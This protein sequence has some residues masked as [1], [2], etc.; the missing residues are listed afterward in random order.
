VKH[1]TSCT[2]FKKYLKNSLVGFADIVIREL[3]LKIH[4][5]TLHE[6]GSARWASPPGR[7]WIKDGQLV[8]DDDGKIQY[9]QVIEF[10]DR[11]TRDAFSA[12]VWRAVE[13]KGVS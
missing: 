13:A 8:T 12:A 10:A 9:S 7:A 3:K 4:D 2:S 5:V 1:T 11:E 6:K